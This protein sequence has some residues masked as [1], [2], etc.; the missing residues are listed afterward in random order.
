MRRGRGDDLV[1]L[2]GW[3]LNA[4][5]WLTLA[6]DLQSTW[7][8]NCVDLPGHGR[9]PLCAHTL[10]EHVDAL[11]EVAPRRAVWLGWSLGGMLA[12][13]LASRFPQRVRSLVLV[14]G[15]ARFVSDAHWTCAMPAPRLA[16]FHAGLRTDWRAV[17]QR[18]LLLQARGSDHAREDV[19]RL[20]AALAVAGEPG[21]D[22]LDNGLRL[23]GSIDLRDDLARLDCPV[24]LVMGQRDQLIPCEAGY[25]MQQSLPHA[26]LRVIRGAGHAPF[27]S[28]R[29]IF[30]QVLRQFLHANAT[31]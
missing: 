21:R 9:S 17:L 15:T 29:E 10:D 19:R 31:V 24:L 3:G 12:L 4:A 25:A 22:A 6:D 18:F 27:I 30:L 2:H 16:R 26:T 5:V 7:R 14:A 28:H 8:L 20:R 11:L 23:L 1:M 13:R